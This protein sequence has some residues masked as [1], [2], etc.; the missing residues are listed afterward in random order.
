MKINIIL[1]ANDY[2][3]RW[4]KL[5]IYNNNFLIDDYLC[6]QHDI[7]LEYSVNPLQDN[8][9]TLEFYNKCF[10]DGGIWDAGNDGEMK[11]Q[12]VD[13]LFDDVSIDHLIHLIEY[14]TNWTPN[15]LIYEPQ[16]N[17]DNYSKYFNNGMITFNGCMSFEYSIPIYNFL[18][19][20][21][22]K[23]QYENNIAYF[24]NYTETFHYEKGI[25]KIAEIRKII[26]EHG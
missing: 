3:D 16:E 11:L 26:K 5:K 19:N 25:E 22:F 8:K 13:L 15:Q 18:I 7:S 12:L 2:K 24:S 17:I 14:K 10:G 23:T 9:L 6:N 1:Q 21:K 4:P 20:K